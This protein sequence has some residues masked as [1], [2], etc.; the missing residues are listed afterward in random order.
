MAL[1]HERHMRIE[2]LDFVMH[3]FVLTLMKDSLLTVFFCIG[4]TT[5]WTR[6]SGNVTRLNKKAPSVKVD[7]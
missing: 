6:G 2:I 4:K 1:I 5:H 3:T 7:V